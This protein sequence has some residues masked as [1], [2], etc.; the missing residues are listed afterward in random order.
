MPRPASR[1]PGLRADAE[2]NRQRIVDSARSAFAEQGLEVSTNE[3]ARRAGVGVATLFRRFPTREELVAAA[4]SD[5]MREYS[6][7]ID[8]ALAQGDPWLGFCEYVRSVASMQAGDRGFNNLMTQS[9][10]TAKEFEAL[11]KEAYNRVL[12]LIDRAKAAGGL[13]ADFVAEDLPLL[14]MANAGVVSATADSAP[15]ASPR[16]VAY[17]LQSFA[18][19]NTEPLP[20]APTPRR[21]YRALLRLHK[22]AK[23]SG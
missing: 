1:D 20:L 19:V 21:M 22:K 18:A 16:L 9:F 2:R 10:P 8:A 14:L 17:L 5:K 3:I 11:R 6:S 4:F 13:R 15:E 7:A 12:E 23:P